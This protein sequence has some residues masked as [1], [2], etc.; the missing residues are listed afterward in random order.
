MN[1]ELYCQQ[2]FQHNELCFNIHTNK[3]SKALEN[4]YLKLY[5]METE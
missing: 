2:C 3:L 4:K 1:S 5:I